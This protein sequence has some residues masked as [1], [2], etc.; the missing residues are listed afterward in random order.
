MTLHGPSSS[1]VQIVQLELI[2]PADEPPLTSGAPRRRVGGGQHGAGRFSLEICI[3][4]Q[5]T[6]YSIFQSAKLA[7]EV[8]ALVAALQL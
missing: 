6:I 5:F 1:S 7:T 2:G 3:S 4:N 8:T